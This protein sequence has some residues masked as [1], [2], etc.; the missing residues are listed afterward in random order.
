MRKRQCS[1]VLALACLA[2]CTSLPL[3]SGTTG[4]QAAKP[5]LRVSTDGFPSGHS[6][7]EGAASD[8]VRSLINRD[9]KLFSST[10]VRLYARG[11]G[12][13]AYAQFLRQTLQNIRQEAAKKEPSPGGP[14]SIGKVFAARHLSKNGP[15]SY[16]YATF[17]FQD[18]M[19]VDVGIFLHNGERSMMR[20]LVIKDSDGKWYVHPAPS[21]SPLLSDGLD[22]E[23]ASDL[24]FSDA[25]E[26]ER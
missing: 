15:A 7:P 16:G 19:F 13:A 11:D 22:E 4:N 1:S 26:L 24:D 21:A 2:V 20:T 3:W 8:V 6:T 23:K 5:K 14:K 25:Y 9:E 10:C 17:G 12:P 18:I